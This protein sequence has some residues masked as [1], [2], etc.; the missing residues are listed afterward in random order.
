MLC[1]I[2]GLLLST[3]ISVVKGLGRAGK[4]TV[5]LLERDEK[6]ILS[7]KDSV[8]VYFVGMTFPGTRRNRNIQ[9]R[10]VYVLLCSVSL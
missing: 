6:D 8:H 1:V 4:N 2:K 3:Q 9:T 7:I 10:Y 5:F